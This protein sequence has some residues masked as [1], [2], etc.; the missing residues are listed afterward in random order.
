VGISTGSLLRLG[1]KSR[2]ISPI[3]T[4]TSRFQISI[5]TFLANTPKVELHL[6]L[7]GSASLGTVADLA[8]QHP[9]ANI[10]SSSSELADWFTFRDFPHF[11][12]LYAR[13]TS[14][15]KTGDDI[16]TLVTGA[17][18][19]LVSHNVVY[20]EMTVT[21][22]MHTIR[23]VPYDEVL[24]GLAVGHARAAD[25]GVDLAWIYD[26]PGEHGQEAARA[27]LDAALFNPP[28]HLVGFGLAGVEAGVSRRDF[29]WAFDQAV[30]AGLGSV[31][32][33]GEGA[34]PASVWEALD[35]LSPD[36]LGHGVRAV[37]DP[38]L[39]ERLVNESVPLEICPS[40]NVCT[41]LYGSITEHPIGELIAA[42]AL[43]TINTD[44]PHMFN[45]SLTEEYMKVAAAIDLDR[46]SLTRIISNA[47]RASFLPATRKKEILAEIEL[48]SSLTD[49]ATR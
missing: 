30:A 35:H 15:V 23:G 4:S 9:E 12:D 13:V 11:I 45:T 8:A 19:D 48:A 24:A 26:I 1:H 49:D 32:H 16:A 31:P 47:V 40:S 39:V 33:A 20:A 18:V 27:T 25:L 7:V 46:C 29:A 37:E 42:G 36:R 10:P 44:D 43:V 14:L 34:G 21:P 17:A 3:S 28:D 2:P 41:Q 5:S 6:H 22:Y 38:K